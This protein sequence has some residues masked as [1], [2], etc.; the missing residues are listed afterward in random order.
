M[1]FKEIG[2]QYNKEVSTTER[3]LLRIIKR[4]FDLEELNNAASI[5]SII[6]E[7]MA[8]YKASINYEPAPVLSLNNKVGITHLDIH[9]L[10]GELLFEKQSSFN[11]DFGSII[12]TICEG[13]DIRLKDSRE[14]NDHHHKMI[15]IVDLE[16]QLKLLVKEM[17]LYS[18]HIHTNMELLKI[19]HYTGTRPQ[20]NLIELETIGS[21]ITTLI[22]VLNIENKTINE[23]LETE[24][25]NINI[26][27]KEVYLFI[28]RLQKSIN[29]FDTLLEKELKIYIDNKLQQSL[30]SIKEEINAYTNKVNANLL[31]DA[32]NNTRYLVAEREIDM[33]ELLELNN[34]GE[35][36]LYMYTNSLLYGF[37][38]ETVTEY[39]GAARD[40]LISFDSTNNILKSNLD[41]SEYQIILSTNKYKNY[42]HEITIGSQGIDDDFITIVIAADDTLSTLSLCISTGPQERFHNF[43]VV[44]NFCHGLESEIAYD[45]TFTPS[46]GWSSYPEGV[47]IRIER[48][49][50]NIKIYRSELGN[51]IISNIPCV[52]IDLQSSF[53]TQEFSNACKYGYGWYSQGQCEFKDF[54]FYGI[55]E[56][57]IFDNYYKNQ[58]IDTTV[59]SSD[60]NADTMEI[61]PIFTYQGMESLFPY[62]SKEFS[63]ECGKTSSDR[64]YIRICPCKYKIPL[65]NNPY[66]IDGSNLYY[67]VT[68]NLT[69]EEAKIYCEERDGHLVNIKTLEEEV[70]IENFILAA[71]SPSISFWIGGTDR[72]TE[73]R[74]KWSNGETFYDD[75]IT[76]EG[77]YSN[78]QDGEPNN[79]GGL[80]HFIE[81]AKIENQFVWNDIPSNENTRRFSIGQVENY[82][83]E[84][85]IPIEF[86]NSK[87]KYKIYAKK[88]PIPYLV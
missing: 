3:Y 34:S 4:Y 46:N 86:L 11:K 58:I 72:E 5:N 63:I 56:L 62:I 83:T 40:S 80:E 25:N 15:S 64:I 9:D 79:A 32:L 8:R 24:N 1:G 43:S 74:W 42:I 88:N 70:A 66:V 48:M 30:E 82:T 17:I 39:N 28:K 13:N 71:Q 29:D 2:N 10:K 36:L 87:L 77:Y 75:G 18:N 45:D 19:L 6:I 52:S 84:V 22:N 33:A 44:T 55:N 16:E 73:G 85:S 49:E 69:W 76:L 14:P 35:N 37:L 81:F 21:K 27:L 26:L 61:E 53:F 57:N 51:S 7:A 65:T 31:I 78:W 59:L 20:V 54:N 68:E 50:N 23:V 12:N 47:H 60:Y 38:N 67:I 41:V